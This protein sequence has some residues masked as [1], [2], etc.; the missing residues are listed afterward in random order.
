[1]I[2]ELFRESIGV[3]RWKLCRALDVKSLQVDER[4][5]AGKKIFMSRNKTFAQPKQFKGKVTAEAVTAAYSELA[6][7]ATP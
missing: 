1:M 2:F 4:F 5:L 7:L 6:V 3:L